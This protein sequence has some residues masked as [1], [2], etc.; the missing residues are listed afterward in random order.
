MSNR[1]PEAGALV[2]NIRTHLET[3]GEF[4]FV[5]KRM[6]GGIGFMVNGNLACH[7]RNGALLVRVNPGEIDTLLQL[8]ST[9]IAV[10]G[11]REMH[12][13]INL[14]SDELERTTLD[15]WVQR[16]VD[17]ALSLPAKQGATAGQHQ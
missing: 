16:G 12:G 13:W 15:E 8:P 11:T 17:Y 3:Q 14:S 6:F 2:Q 5:E 4:E 9:S 7:S 10:M 1:S